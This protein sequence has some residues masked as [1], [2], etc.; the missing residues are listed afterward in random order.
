M[1]L[2]N[3]MTTTL[4]APHPACCFRGSPA[5][6]HYFWRNTPYPPQTNTVYSLNTECI[7]WE[8]ISKSN[9]NNY[10]TVQYGLKISRLENSERQI[11]CACSQSIM[12]HFFENTQYS[13][14][15]LCEIITTK[16]LIKCI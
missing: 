3:I 5:H 1:Q 16:G 8:F 15:E 2:S 10:S 13:C 11:K 14:R 6:L 4:T 9:I 7:F 12:S